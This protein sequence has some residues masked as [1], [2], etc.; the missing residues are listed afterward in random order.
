MPFGLVNAPATFQRLMKVVWKGLAR[1]ECMVY[2]DTLV[3]GKTFKEHNDNLAKVLRQ[4]R[5]ASLILKP[6]KCKFAQLE[7]CYLDHVVSAEG[8]QTDPAKL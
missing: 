8:V 2:L 6:K 5:S 7:V 4:L 3:V 1:D